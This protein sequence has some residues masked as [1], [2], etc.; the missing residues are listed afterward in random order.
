MEPLI[1][2]RN[3]QCGANPGVQGR[4]KAG[5]GIHCDAGLMQLCYL[6]SHSSQ[7][8]TT[9]ANGPSGPI[10]CQ[11]LPLAQA[12]LEFPAEQHAPFKG[13]NCC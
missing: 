12:E 13:D 3:K 4:A 9:A 11:G 8:Q 10:I 1:V 2:A 5:H 7:T 6:E